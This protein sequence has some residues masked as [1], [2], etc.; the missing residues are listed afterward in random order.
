MRIRLVRLVGG[1]HNGFSADDNRQWHG[2]AARTI[3]R[4]RERNDNGRTDN[5]PAPSYTCHRALPG[6]KVLRAN[7]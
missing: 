5:K 4:S 1:K 3:L 7:T 2:V 6:A